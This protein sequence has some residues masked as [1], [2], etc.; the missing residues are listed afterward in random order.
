M[1][2]NPIIKKD[3]IAELE[4]IDTTQEQ[5]MKMDEDLPKIN[6]DDIAEQEEPQKLVKVGNPCT[7]QCVKFIKSELSKRSIV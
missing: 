1:T 3:D 5:K 7:K 4:E 6:K 2:I